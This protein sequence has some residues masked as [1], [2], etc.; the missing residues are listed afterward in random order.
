[1]LF[2][3]YM[4]AFRSFNQVARKLVE[5]K[6]ELEDW[7]RKNFYELLDDAWYDKEIGGTNGR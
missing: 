7:L 2:D 6:P 4:D 1:M 3:K 5:A